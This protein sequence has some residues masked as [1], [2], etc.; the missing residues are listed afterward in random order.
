M[1]FAV[2]HVG[3]DIPYMISYYLCFFCP[4]RYKNRM[5]DG[6]Y[7]DCNRKNAIKFGGFRK[8]LYLC[9]RLLTKFVKTSDFRQ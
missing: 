6:N 3:I 2:L 1:L 5:K 7:C 4:L 9:S 8:K